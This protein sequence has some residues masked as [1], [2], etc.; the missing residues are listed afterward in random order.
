MLIVTFTN[1]AAA[2]M[3]ERIGEAISKELDKDPGSENM[4][5][6]LSLLSRAS[7]MTI[8]SFCKEVITKHIELVEI[9]PNFRIA[10]ETESHLMRIETIN[11]VVNEQYEQDNKDFLELLDWYGGNL[12]DQKIHDM[13]LSIYNFIQSSP[14]PEQWLKDKIEAMKIDETYDFAKTLWGRVILKSCRMELDS[15]RHMLLEQ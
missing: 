7:I 8:H 12:N 2:E 6:Q 14:W 1:A 11:E 10:D 3:R 13:V 4:R 15:A 5:R 9:D